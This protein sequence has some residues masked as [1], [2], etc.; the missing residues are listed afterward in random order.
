MDHCNT[1][2]HSPAGTKMESVN[3]QLDGLNTDTVAKSGTGEIATWCNNG[4]SRC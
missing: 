4:Q 2:T 3:S 1:F